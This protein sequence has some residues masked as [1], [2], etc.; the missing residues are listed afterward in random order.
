[1]YHYVSPA[2]TRRRRRQ[3]QIITALCI[4]L[5][6]ACVS[7]LIAYSRT[8][9]QSNNTHDML[10]AK[11]QL[12]TSNARSRADKLSQ[13]SGSNTAASISLTR[14]HVYAVK[15]LNE[16]TAGIYGAGTYLVDSTK[17]EDCLRLLDDCDTKHAAGLVLTTTYTS[18]RNAVE[19]LY[20][21]AESLQ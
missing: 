15:M 9:K 5:A 20:V 1:M 10:V 13:T 12:E 4:I 14:Q 7:L 6:I 8:S 16:L 11:I 18:L 2:K 17:I 19:I 21:E 3:L